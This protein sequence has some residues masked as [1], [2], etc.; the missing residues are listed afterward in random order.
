MATA[1]LFMG[2]ASILYLA[3]R[4]ASFFADVFGKAD[5]MP[6]VFLLGSKICRPCHRML[7]A[8]MKMK[9][10]HRRKVARANVEGEASGMT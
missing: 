3:V 1:N 5:K 4:F 6:D 10:R 7:E 2:G 8:I 9:K